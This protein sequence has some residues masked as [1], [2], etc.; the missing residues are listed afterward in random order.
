MVSRLWEAILELVFEP[1]TGF[2]QCLWIGSASAAGHNLGIEPRN[3]SPLEFAKRLTEDLGD[4]E[5]PSVG[6]AL[7]Q[8]RLR[9][10]QGMLFDIERQSG[11]PHKRL[12]SH[13]TMQQLAHTLARLRG[14]TR[15]YQRKAIPRCQS[16]E[17]FHDFRDLIGAI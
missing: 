6:L 10:I 8:E 9:L 13:A 7:D 3:A 12:R 11:S 15:A 2:D 4:P 14:M 5:A 1:K 17:S 16:N